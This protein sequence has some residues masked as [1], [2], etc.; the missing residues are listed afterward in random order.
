MKKIL[1][2][3]PVSFAVETAERFMAIG[4]P[5]AAAALSYFLILTLFPLLVCV[6]YFIGLF[7]LDLEN[8]L[9][10]L[11]Q[12]LPAEALAVME[13]YLGYVAGSQSDALLLA[14]LVTILISASAGLRTLLAALDGLHGRTKVPIVRRV[15]FSVGLSALFLLTIYLSVV[16]IFT[17]EWFFW[18]LEEKLPRMIT[19]HIPL[20]ALSGLWRWLRYL[21]LFCFVL[22][23]V[24]IIYRAGTPRRAMGN[25][26][27]VLSSLLAALA[28]A[29]A[30]VLFSWF[31]GMSSRYALV[32]GSLASL[33]ILL[34][35]LYLCGNILLLGAVAGRVMEE[36]LS[37]QPSR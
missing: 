31:I 11:D 24:L 30:S 23:L 25:R 5:R 36:R 10:S 8:L 34:V 33:I 9:R 1:S 2:F 26:I 18:V 21:L 7:H 19:E 32:Y 28:I 35:W 20:P 17:G 27:V 16:V 29:A 13:D 12:F 15:L 22:L 3:P 37:R 6:N 14:S 4:A